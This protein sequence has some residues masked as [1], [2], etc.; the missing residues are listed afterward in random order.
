MPAY[1]KIILKN[2]SVSGAIPQPAFLEYGE[3]ALNYADGYLYYKDSDNQVI[4]YGDHDSAVAATPNTKV[5]RD[6]FGSIFASAL[7]IVPNDTV[8][9]VGVTAKSIGSFGAI[10]STVSGTYSH[11][12]KNDNSLRMAIQR[13]HGHLYWFDNE[14]SPY[15]ILKPCEES[16]QAQLYTAT[17]PKYTGTL[18]IADTVDGF[19][20]VNTIIGLRSELDNINLDISSLIAAVSTQPGTVNS[21]KIIYVDSVVGNDIRTGRTKYSEEFPFETIEAAVTASVGDSFT[22]E[23]ANIVL[24]GILATVTLQNHGLISGRVITVVGSG[25]AALDVSNVPVSVIDN[26]TFTYTTLTSGNLTGNSLATIT[27]DS[28]ADADL[29][30]VRSGVYTIP[31]QISLNG[32]GNIYCEP[33]VNIYVSGAAAA[34]GLSRNESKRI[35][36]YANFT[37]AATAGLI[38]QSGGSIDLQFNSAA[39]ASSGTLFSITGGSFVG[40][41]STINTPNANAFVLQN[42][43]NLTVHDSYEV[44]CTEFLEC[45]SSGNVNID[46]LK[47]NGNSAD[48]IIRVANANTFLYRGA[49]CTN[50]AN[51]GSCVIFAYTNS[52]NGPTLRNVRLRAS[53]IPLVCD[54]NGTFRDVFLDCVK[55]NSIVTTNPSISSSNKLTRVYSANTCSN[56]LPHTSIIIDGNYNVMSKLF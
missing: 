33:H 10:S 26:N 50:S 23:G 51:S 30:Y 27:L 5:K 45:T 22:V 38:S 46:L 32:K 14:D 43:A 17:L 20:N 21:G 49:D 56:V 6:N 47:I 24:N 11:G 40:K 7:T 54:N 35:N 18:A 8:P 55:I 9:Y 53:G 16:N 13:E 2:S 19:I 39:G 4:I 12:F 42:A 48:T 28:G 36:G 52:G 31:S 34:F 29:I 15:S 25:V 1:N 3:L 44:N 41:F 37:I